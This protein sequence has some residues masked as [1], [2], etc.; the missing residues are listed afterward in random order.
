MITVQCSCG[1]KGMAPPTLAGKT[2]RCKSCSAPISIPNTAPPN[3]APSDIYDIAQ[4]AVGPHVRVASGGPPPIPPLPP[5]PK[6]QS[7]KPRPRAEPGDRSF[8]PD[9]AL[10]FGFMFRPVNLLVL[11]GAVLLALFAELVPVPFVGLI[12]MAILCALY[13][14]TIE[15]TAGGS[16]DLP[17]G[18]NYEGV[19]TSLILPVV[20]FVGVSVILVLFAILLIALTTFNME[21]ESDNAEL[22]G[23]LVV[24]CVA[25]LWPISMLM[26]ALGGVMTLFRVDLMV[27]SIASAFVPYLAIWV[28]LLAAIGVQVGAEMMMGV[29]ETTDSIDPFADAPARAALAVLGIY[30][31]L[32][33][34]RCIGLFYRHYN[35]RFAWSAG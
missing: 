16:D 26:V 12:P 32:V 30:C 25:F 11:I 22:V 17:N 6:P 8:W 3:T 21:P 34:M 19:W 15:A 14:G 7:S 10:S 13:L 5:E 2:V 33:A 9:L 31:M 27:R 18:A 28:A 29:P 4:P 20:R 35:D 23:V 24:A 1:A